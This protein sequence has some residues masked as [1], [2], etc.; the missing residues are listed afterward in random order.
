MRCERDKIS[1]VTV[2]S[3]HVIHYAADLIPLCERKVASFNAQF[4]K[5]SVEIRFD[6]RNGAV[7]H[8]FAVAVKHFNSVIIEWVV[9]SGYHYSAVK[10]VLARNVRNARRCRYMEHIRVG[11]GRGYPGCER[12]LKHV[13]RSSRI[14]S[15][16]YARFVRKR[17]KAGK[18]RGK[19]PSEESSDTV[20]LIGSERYVRLA[21]ES[22]CS[23]IFVSFVRLI[24]RGSFSG[25]IAE[26]IYIFSQ[27][28]VAGYG[29]N[30]A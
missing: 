28:A 1:D 17:M 12:I 19:V 4:F 23:E 10:A 26:N 5:I 13:T 18:R 11:A 3:R 6:K 27:K 2:S 7:V 8:F 16:E 9:R 20:C 29:K 15:D 14:F 25:N 22:V 24:Y 21:P 30:L